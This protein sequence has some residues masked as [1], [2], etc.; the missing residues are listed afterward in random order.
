[1]WAVLLSQHSCSSSSSTATKH[2]KITRFRTSAEMPLMLAWW[3]TSVSSQMT[4]EC[5]LTHVM[6]P[7]HLKAVYSMYIIR[8]ICI[9]NSARLTWHVPWATWCEWRWKPKRIMTLSVS[10]PIK[11]AFDQLAQR[12][13]FHTLKSSPKTTVIEYLNGRGEIRFFIYN[14]RPTGLC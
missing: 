3:L 4:L 2:K 1:M 8:L 9:A 7:N 10:S 11:M 5:L 6:T 13:Q 12:N 14:M